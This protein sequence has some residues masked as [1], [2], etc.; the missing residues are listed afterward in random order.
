MNH[1]QLRMPFQHPAYNQCGTGQHITYSERDRGLRS[2]QTGQIW[3]EHV[4]C[5]GS[6][7]GMNSKRHVQVL[8][9]IPQRLVKTVIKAM[10]THRYVVDMHRFEAELANAAARLACSLLRITKIDGSSAKYPP[11]GLGTEIMQPVVVGAPIR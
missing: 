5:C 7:A 2:P 9:C 1:P 6:G 10:I 4:I 3:I 8:Q 11:T